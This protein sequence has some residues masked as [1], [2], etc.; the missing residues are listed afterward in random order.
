M[1]GRITSRRVP[2][3]LPVDPDPGS[4]GYL[5]ALAQKFGGVGKRQAFLQGAKAHVLSN[6]YVGAKVPT[7]QRTSDLPANTFDVR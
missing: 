4:A 5:E 1:P 7:S 2:A 3:R 6:L